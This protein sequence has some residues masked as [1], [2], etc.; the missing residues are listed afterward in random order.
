M[1]LGGSTDS[2]EETRFEAEAIRLGKEVFLS[3]VGR[4]SLQEEVGQIS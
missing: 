1:D 2:G 4:G 3:D